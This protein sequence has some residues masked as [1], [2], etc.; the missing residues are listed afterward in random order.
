[1]GRG[2]GLSVGAA[3]GKHTQAKAGARPWGT[4]C[5]RGRGQGAGARQDEARH[6]RGHSEAG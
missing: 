1:M 2:N 6:E 4:A 3:G 5:L